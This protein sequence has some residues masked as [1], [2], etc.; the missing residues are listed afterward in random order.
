MK[1]KL[2]NTSRLLLLLSSIMLIATLF[3]P[4]WRIELDAP[5]YPE[6]LVLL[7]HADKL[8]GD[9][10]IINGLNHYIGMKTLHTENFFEFT[11][12]P[13]I[14]CFFAIFGVV[15]IIANRKKIA[16]ALLVTFLVFGV[17]A[18]ID[19]Y[20]WNY[21]YGHN[22]DPNAAIKVPGMAYQP[23]M[24]GF[25]Q[26][27]NF[28]AYS[29]PDTGGWLLILAGVLMV[30]VVCIEF[31]L[32]KKFKKKSASVAALLLF[33]FGLTS[34]GSSGP[35]PISLNT[36]QCD[37]C[38]M[39]ISDGK[40]GAEILTEKGRVY[41]F[42]DISCMV[43][44]TKAIDAKQKPKAYFIHDYSKENVLIPAESAFYIKGEE[45]NSP[46]RGNIAAFSSAE[47][48]DKFAADL[49]AEKTDWKAIIQ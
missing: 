28:G 24:I 19:F 36:D 43:T 33:A 11:V 2:S 39:S 31:N 27:L 5:Q 35:Q 42:D 45:I 40:F 46:M 4:V 48:A 26:L 49:A 21:D 18:G 7:L 1:N 15:A 47:D 16:L 17:L 10:E 41:K 37:F 23:P 9:V 22:L 30:V 3:F 20:R 44:Y 34:C 12:L 6:G 29:I 32:F 25:K 13:Y 8:A 38:K 14:L